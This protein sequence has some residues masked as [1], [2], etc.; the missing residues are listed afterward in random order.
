MIIL[1]QICTYPRKNKITPKKFKTMCKNLFLKIPSNVQFEILVIGDDYP[2]LKKDFK[3]ILK[4]LKIE[5]KLININQNDALRNMESNKMLKWHHACTRSLIYG[6]K[7]S[8]DGNYDYIITLSDDDDYDINYLNEIVNTIITHPNTDLIYGL[9][10]YYNKGKNKFVI[11]P[12]KYDSILTKNSPSRCDTIA[13]GIVFKS[14]N[15]EFIE[16]IIQMLEERWQIVINNLHQADQPN[17]ALMWDHLKPKFNNKIYNSILI[18]KV[19][20]FHDTEQSLFENI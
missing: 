11:M 3:P 16:D 14:S 6:F 20:V 8:L 5:Y 9:G 4:S 13:S 18:P 12:R 2:K 17:D 1:L 15:K 7:Y 10:R 19:I